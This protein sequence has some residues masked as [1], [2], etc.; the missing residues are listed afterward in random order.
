MFWFLDTLVH[1]RVAHADGED[2]I[3][4]LDST[5]RRGDSP[6]LHVHRTED[7]VFYVL[8]GEVDVRIGD[9]TVTAGA[10]DVLLAPKGVPHTYLV[11]SHRARMLV[12]TTNGD[13]E[14]FVRELSRPAEADDLPPFAGPPAR[15]QIEALGEAAA[16]HG[17]DLVGPPLVD[18]ALT[19][20]VA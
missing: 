20:A 19:S 11:R 16:R 14:R 6:P 8:E 10:G 12:T 5:A 4:I 15:E 13:F 1:V 2:G 18:P 17:I 3:S 9:E 7:E